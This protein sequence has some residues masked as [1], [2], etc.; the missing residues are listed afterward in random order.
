MLCKNCGSEVSDN[1]KYCK[2]CG[3]KTNENET[4]KN[5]V[6]N[7]VSSEDATTYPKKKKRG[8]LKVIFITGA[9]VAG[10]AGLCTYGLNKMIEHEMKQ[11][12]NEPIYYDVDLKGEIL[13]DED[14][15][16]EALDAAQYFE[17]RSDVLMQYSAEE[18][19]EI[20]TEQDVLV[21]LKERGFE[22]IPVTTVYMMDGDYIEPVEIRSDST[23]KHPMYYFMHNTEDGNVWVIY[24]V[25]GTVMADPVLY[26]LQ[27]GKEVSYI[28]SETGTVKSYDGTTNM[29]FETIPDEKEMIVIK[30]NEINVDEIKRWTFEEMNKYENE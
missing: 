26:N 28:L 18:S 23:T 30:V 5:T 20:L 8:C 25:D 19:D 21:K 27:S 9:I 1:A 6:S 17:E 16:V 12:N 15:E 3:S 4:L 14:Y 7:H 13:E 29:F 10:L 11:K 22:N 24:V 2:E